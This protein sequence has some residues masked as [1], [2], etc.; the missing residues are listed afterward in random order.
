MTALLEMPIASDFVP[1][2]ERRVNPRWK[3]VLDLLV[4][5]VAAPCLS[6][7]LVAVALHIRLVSP[8]PIL[9]LQSRVGYGGE[10]FT[11]Y[12]FRTMHVA[13]RARD[14]GH[15]NYVVAHAGTGAPVKK[16]DFR[17]ELIPGGSL[18]RKLSIDEF[19]QLI[20]V[21]LGNMSIVGPRPDLMQVQDYEPW[22][23]KRFEVLPGMTGLW[24]VSGKNELSLEEMIDLDIRYAR[25][26]SVIGDLKIILKTFWVLV[27][28]RNE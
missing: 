14:V 18:L 23:L 4:V 11:I 10:L 21:F 9:F 3:R 27:S 17:Q 6:P 24:Q 20:N 5:L 28:E 2:I 26:R 22:Q 19:P 16:P 25:H 15:R 12:K 1:S 8:G 13:A 7:L